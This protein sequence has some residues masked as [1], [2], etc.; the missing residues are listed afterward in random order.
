MAKKIHRCL[1]GGKDTASPLQIQRVNP[2]SLAERYGIL[3]NDYILRI[4][5]V[6]TEYLDHQSAQE[7][8]KR[9]SNVLEL[10]LQRYIYR[11]DRR[12]TCQ[13]CLSRGAPP[14]NAD[15]NSRLN[16]SAQIPFYPEPTAAAVRPCSST[17]SKSVCSMRLTFSLICFEVIMPISNE[18][19]MLN[20]S[21]NTP[22]WSLFN[23]EY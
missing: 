16:S 10:T 1:S 22:N 4:G 19:V 9:Y 15:Y 6:S 3:N 13:Y 20:Q 12:K 23:R 21:F 2:N 14:S 18:K 8:I 17:T 5:Q 7:Q 11:S